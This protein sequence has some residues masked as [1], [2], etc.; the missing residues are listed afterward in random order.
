MNDLNRV[1]VLKKVI[2]EET[3]IIKYLI[4]GV[5]SH[6]DPSIR[7]MACVMADTTAY[8]PHQCNQRNGGA[9]FDKIHA[10]ISS[11]GEGIERYCAAFSNKKDIILASYKELGDYAIHPSK[12]PLFSEKQ[13]AEFKKLGI[14]YKKFTEDLKLTWVKGKSLLTGEERYVP[15]QFVYIPFNKRPDEESI[16]PSISTGMA[17]GESYEEAVYYGLLENFER[18][19]L[20]IWWMQM[21]PYPN[22][23]ANLTDNNLYEYFKR[24]VDPMWIKYIYT[25]FKVP[26]IVIIGVMNDVI[27][28]DG[29]RYKALIM[30]S[31]SRLSPFKA[32][33]KALLEM[34]QAFPFYKYIAQS[35]PKN[36]KLESPN[37]IWDFDDHSRFWYLYTNK[38]TKQ[39]EKWIGK[40]E[41]IPLES[42]TDLDRNN[43]HENLEFLKSLLNEKDM[44]AVVVDLTTPDIGSLGFKVV[45]VMIPELVPLEGA[46]LLR[47]LGAKRLYEVPKKLGFEY[48]EENKLNPLPHPSP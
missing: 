48:F 43:L 12:W 28:P 34:G 7:S 47:H 39:L 41:T 17:F 15:A 42:I 4:E 16:G 45:K 27:F 32:F 9:G 20:S 23:T 14:P 35:F 44:D 11:I 22:V 26:V 30:G 29:Q 6:T 31:A 36:K 33:E 13:Y 46:H 3:G 24:V 8:L 19:A 2:D 37:D 21:L 1:N 38:Y 25:D 18:E 5:L 10:M 40:G